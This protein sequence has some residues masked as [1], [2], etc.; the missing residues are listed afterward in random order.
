MGP[1]ILRLRR[2]PSQ[3]LRTFITLQR[4]SDYYRGDLG[5][6]FWAIPSASPSRMLLK[7]S[8]YYISR[9]IGETGALVRAFWFLINI[10]SA[11]LLCSCISISVLSPSSHT[12]YALII[13]SYGVT[14]IMVLTWSLRLPVAAFPISIM[15]THGLHSR[16]VLSI[17]L[18]SRVIRGSFNPK[19]EV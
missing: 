14:F 10:L 5:L 1:I 8:S 4:E 15:T 2:F 6:E 13:A 17:Y 7:W 16:L 11:N 12:D 3:S 9:F 18:C 19:V